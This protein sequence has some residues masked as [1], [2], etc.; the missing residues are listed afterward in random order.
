MV[1]VQR[2]LN[3]GDAPRLRSWW[4]LFAASMESRRDIVN[5]GERGAMNTGVD[6]VLQNGLRVLLDFICLC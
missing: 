3:S 4:W 2:L 6:K 5:A 1:A